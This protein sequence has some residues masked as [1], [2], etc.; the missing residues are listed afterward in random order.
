MLK[1]LNLGIEEVRKT[2]KLSSGTRKTVKMGAKGK[3]I[4]MNDS[5]NDELSEEQ[6]RNMTGT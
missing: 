4:K 6:I 2:R 3:T 5:P 1:T